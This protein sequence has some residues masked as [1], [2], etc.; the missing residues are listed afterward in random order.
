MTDW[1]VKPEFE[2]PAGSVPAASPDGEPERYPAQVLAAHAWGV[3]DANMY[4]HDDNM[5]VYLNNDLD[6]YLK[7][8]GFAPVHVGFALWSLFPDAGR[9]MV[10]VGVPYEGFAKLT[11]GQ[12]AAELYVI[13]R[14]V[15]GQNSD[16][17]GEGLESVEFSAPDGSDV[18]YSIDWAMDCEVTGGTTENKAAPFGMDVFDSPGRTWT[19]KGPDW[20]GEYHDGDRFAIIRYSGAM[21]GRDPNEDPEYTGSILDAPDD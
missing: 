8:G 18:E 2:A 7:D 13:G 4:V 12:R 20:R 21:S 1:D 10:V 6:L 19:Y 3:D 14:W 15:T 5:E 16:G 17:L 9:F 11:D